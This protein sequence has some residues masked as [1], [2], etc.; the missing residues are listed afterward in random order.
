[1][2]FWE[3]LTSVVNFMAES[4]SRTA[5]SD[6]R[7][8]EE[9]LRKGNLTD[10]Q[11]DAF[12]KAIQEKRKAISKAKDFIIKTANDD[13]RQAEEKLR[14]KNLTESERA[15]LKKIIEQK[16]AAIFRAKNN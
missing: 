5:E 6:I 14:N 10:S 9:M 2:G 7:R 4:G 3:G 16:R 15:D 12:Q 11:R 13:I 8:F 1:M